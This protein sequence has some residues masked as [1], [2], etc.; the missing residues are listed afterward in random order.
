MEPDTGAV[1]YFT[2]M[3]GDFR[4]YLTGT[5]CCVA[6]SLEYTPRFNEGIYS[7]GVD[8]LWVN[9]YI[10]STVEWN[11]QQITLAESGDVASGEET[12]KFIVT[13]CG[14]P[15][16]VT[17]SFRVPYWIAAPAVLSLNGAELSRSIKPSTYLSATRVWHE[18][19][20]I[21]L[22]LPRA[23]RLERAKD[24]PS[25]VSIFYGPWLLAGELG[26]DHMPNDVGDKDANLNESPATVPT[27]VSSSS[28]PND[29][30]E[31]EPNSCQVFQFKQVGPASGIRCRPLYDLHHERYSVY[32]PLRLHS[33]AVD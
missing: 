22:R 16:P 7:K 21:T 26:R 9:L 12:A 32:W 15:K 4:T 10:P 2:P 33:R 5:F 17:L 24:S 6:S 27:I 14:S 1:T 20:T 29:W 28:D 13:H 31:L 8:R 18:G 19:D 23:L 30:L 11:E 25:L 3:Y